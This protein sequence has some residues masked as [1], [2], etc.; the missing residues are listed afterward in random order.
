L[1]SINK[2]K[3]SLISNTLENIEYL[4]MSEVKKGYVSQ[5]SKESEEK[6]AEIQGRINS[7]DDAF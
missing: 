3:G 6:K 4:S 2:R 5:I 1:E 7:F